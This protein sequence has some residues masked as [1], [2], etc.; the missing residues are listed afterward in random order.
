MQIL[1]N[2]SLTIYLYGRKLRLNVD[3]DKFMVST[4]NGKNLT[5]NVDIDKFIVCHLRA[6]LPRHFQ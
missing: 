1:M 2:L 3:I 5:C 6:H 4:S